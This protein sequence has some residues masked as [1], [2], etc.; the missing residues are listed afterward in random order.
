MN[1]KRDMTPNEFVRSQCLRSMLVISTAHIPKRTADA[2]GQDRETLCKQPLWD[3]LSY[4]RWGDYGWFI[5][6]CEDQVKDLRSGLESH[7]ELADLIEFC[8]LN[9]IE[10]L[11][12]D[13]DAFAYP[14]APTFD[15]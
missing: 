13:C 7:R 1:K 9:K 5:Y 12:L 14:G 11:L 2:L 10:Y 8:V 4:E 15:W 3:I 6:C